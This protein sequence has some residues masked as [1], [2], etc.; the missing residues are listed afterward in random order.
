[1]RFAEN[2]IRNALRKNNTKKLSF[3]ISEY[4]KMKSEIIV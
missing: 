4:P 2:P 3:T 1:M